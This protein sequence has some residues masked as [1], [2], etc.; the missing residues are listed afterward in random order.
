MNIGEN[1]Q[2][3]IV[4][5]TKVGDEHTLTTLL[6]VKSALKGCTAELPPKATEP[7][8]MRAE[9]EREIAAI[10]AYLPHPEG[11]EEIRK[12]VRGAIAHLQKDAGGVKPGAKDME[13]AIQVAQQ[14]IRAAGLQADRKLVSEIVKAELA[15]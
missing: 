8:P 11:Y 13:T 14:W 7:Q 5:A 1:I 10:D 3:D 2:A 9:T 12:L 6:M 15:P 4:M